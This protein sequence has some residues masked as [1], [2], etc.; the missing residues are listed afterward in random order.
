MQVDSRGRAVALKGIPHVFDSDGDA[1]AEKVAAAG[2]ERGL[3]P[4]AVPADERGAQKKTLLIKG[5]VLTT[6]G[7][8]V[9]LLMME[10]IEQAAHTLSRPSTKVV[11]VAQQIDPNYVRAALRVGASAYVVKQ[12]APTELL[13][14]VKVALEGKIYVTPPASARRGKGPL[15]IAPLRTHER[16][17]A[18]GSHRVSLKCCS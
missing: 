8:C 9:L 12:S 1:C 16:C 5:Q 4:C 7:D 18:R 17:L 3:L 6:D 15:L 13:Q 11:F 14:A 2:P 10:E